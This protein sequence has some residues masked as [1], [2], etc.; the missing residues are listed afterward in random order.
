MEIYKITSSS[1]R[2]NDKA[3]FIV[4]KSIGPKKPIYFENSLRYELTVC[5][6]LQI[7]NVF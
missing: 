1:E 4:N 3:R 6:G 7:L 5:C 2:G